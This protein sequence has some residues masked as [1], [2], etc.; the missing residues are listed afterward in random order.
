[1]SYYNETAAV[2]CPLVVKFTTNV[3]LAA[4]QEC[5][6][7]PMKWFV[8]MLCNTFHSGISKHSNSAEF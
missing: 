1:M 8:Y 5:A 3:L 7:G 6:N 4:A 2:R